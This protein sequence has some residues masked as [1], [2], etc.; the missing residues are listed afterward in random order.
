MD[1]LLLTIVFIS[2]LFFL[3]GSGVWIGLS[4][5]GVALSGMWLF[6]MRPAGDAMVTTIWTSSS[7]WTLTALPLLDRK[8]VV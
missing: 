8:S 2:A 7:S 4:L 5:I 3:L 6:T 1:E